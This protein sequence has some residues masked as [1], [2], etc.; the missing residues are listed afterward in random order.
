MCSVCPQDASLT[1]VSSINAI[2]LA[3]QIKTRKLVLTGEGAI[4]LQYPESMS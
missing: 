2:E 1:T 4:L 3:L